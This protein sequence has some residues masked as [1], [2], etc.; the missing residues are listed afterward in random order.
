MVLVV[1][2]SLLVFMLAL[3]CFCVATVFSVNE[4]L[5]KSFYLRHGGLFLLI[6]PDRGLSAHRCGHK[7]GAYLANLSRPTL[8]AHLH[9][10]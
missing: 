4:D 3:L 10:D 7:L 9:R 1:V 5:Y 6:S 2:F 8:L